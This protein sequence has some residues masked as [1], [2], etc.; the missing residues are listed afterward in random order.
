[1]SCNILPLETRFV[2]DVISEPMSSTHPPSLNEVTP[3]TQESNRIGY[4][5]SHA[6]LGGAFKAFEKY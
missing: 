5:P 4:D 2:K 6:L 1:M 3:E